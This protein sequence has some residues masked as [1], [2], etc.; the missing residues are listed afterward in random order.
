MN[1]N[2]K[3]NVYKDLNL[4]VLEIET[5]SSNNKKLKEICDLTEKNEYLTAYSLSKI[6]ECSLI[7]AK[8]L[9]LDAEKLGLLCRDDTSRGLRFYTNLFLKNMI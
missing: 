9:L 4:H 5:S 2:M 3:Y 8:K 7:V 1:L 6:N